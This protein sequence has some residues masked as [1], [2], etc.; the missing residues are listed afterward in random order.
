LRQRIVAAVAGEDVV[1]AVAD[2]VEAAGAGG[3]E[4]LD[5]GE[6]ARR[7]AGTAG[8]Q[9]QGVDE[10]ITYTLTVPATWGTPT[11]TPA[12][13]VFS[14]IGEVYADVTA[15][16]MPTGTPSVNGQVIILPQI[17][18]L[19]EGVTYRVEMKFSTSE[20]DVKEAYAWI[21]ALR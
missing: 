4:I 8:R 1:A 14:L 12:V 16:V 6:H 9:E 13:E 17:K 5:A 21:D 10:E 15:D 20:G 2:Q 19:A 11:G 3:G 7:I 18:D